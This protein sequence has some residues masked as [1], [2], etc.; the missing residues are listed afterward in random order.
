MYWTRTN[1]QSI[2]ASNFCQTLIY[3][4][5]IQPFYQEF[6]PQLGHLAA[7]QMFAATIKQTYNLVR[8][9]IM[10]RGLKDSS[11]LRRLPANLCLYT[12]CKYLKIVTNHKL[13]YIWQN[14]HWLF[15][16]PSLYSYIRCYKQLVA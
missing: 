14:K 10:H 6:E 13:K 5:N 4:V 16:K 15:K 12:T 7:Q 9:L 3:F 1:L 8:I 2:L 11:K